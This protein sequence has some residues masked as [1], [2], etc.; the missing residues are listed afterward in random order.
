M[1]TRLLIFLMFV[2]GLASCEQSQISTNTEN[3]TNPETPSDQGDVEPWMSMQLVKFT[4]DKYREYILAEHIGDGPVRMR[5]KTPPVV[6]ELI[7]GTIPYSVK[8]PNGY[9][10]IDWRWGN[11]FIYRPSNVLLSYKWETLTH[12]SQTWDMPENPLAF[13]EYFEEV[14]G[15]TRRTIDNFLGI[16]LNISRY[17]EYGDLLYNRPP[18]VFGGGFM[19]D[20]DIPSAEREHYYECV[21][22]QDSLHEIYTQRLIE[23]INNGDFEK[24]YNK[25]P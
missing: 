15:V 18:L 13:D 5:G 19:S 23:I 22:Q 16:N 1:K 14:G 25:L 4:D 21:H 20:K 3:Q 10:L 9:W 24:V 7:V 8:L 6:E 11:S 17:S 12:W 2:Y